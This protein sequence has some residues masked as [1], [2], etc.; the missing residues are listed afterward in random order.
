[1]VEL[2]HMLAAV[3]ARGDMLRAAAGAQDKSS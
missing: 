3:K 1:M 2:E